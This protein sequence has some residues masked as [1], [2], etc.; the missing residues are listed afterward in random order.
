MGLV[1]S[2]QFE[3]DQCIDLQNTYKKSYK[4]LKYI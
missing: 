3:M 1:F 4:L 2:E